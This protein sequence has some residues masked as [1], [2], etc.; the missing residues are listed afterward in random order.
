MSRLKNDR[1]FNAADMEPMI[2]SYHYTFN[3]DRPLWSQSLLMKFR[4]LS[5]LKST[6]SDKTP[7]HFWPNI[8]NFRLY[9]LFGA[10]S[11]LVTDI[12]DEMCWWQLWD[13]G[14][15]LSH[16][17]HQ[18]PLSLNISVGHQHQKDVTNVSKFCHQH[19]KIV[20]NIKSPTSTCHQQLCSRF[21]AMT[22]LPF[23]PTFGN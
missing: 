6:T 18:H 8:R 11:M 17:S 20:T 12:G 19:P 21:L 7:V 23:L 3:E 14:D 10:S 22:L 9:P 2:S 5:T 16:F 1:N 4:P 15:G 13:V